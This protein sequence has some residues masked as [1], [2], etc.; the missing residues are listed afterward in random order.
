MFE[1]ITPVS[2][3]ILTI[4]WLV[5]LGLYLG[6]LRQSKAVGGTVAVLL[7]ILAI[8]AFR[9]L[10]ES[11]YFGLY[12]NSLYGFL[13]KGIHEVLLQP[14]LISIPKLINIGAGLLVLFLLIRR[15]L[16]RELRERE[17]WILNLEKAKHV[18]EEKEASLSAIFNGIPDAIMFTDTERR[19]ISINS[20]MEKMFGYTIEDLAGKTTAMLYESEEEYQR[21]GRIR[22]NLSAEEITTPYQVNYKRKNGKIFIGEALG[23][24]I[25]EA[26]GE[27][28][29]YIGVI[30]DITERKHTEDQL[31]TALVDA[32]RANQAK[33][34]FLATMSH[35][36][37]TPLNAILGFS[38]MLRS[39]YFG[40]LG[41]DN[42]NIYAN[43]IHTSGEHMLDLVNDMLDVAAI[44]AGKRPMINEDVDIGEIVKDCVRNVEPAAKNSGINLS[45]DVPDGAASLYTDK[46]SII[47]IVYN[48][49]SN[50]LKFTKPGGKV[51]VSVKAADKK[52]SIMVSDTG[53]G[54]SPDKLPTVTDPFSQTHTDPYITQHGTGLGLSIVK[55]LVEAYDG[56]LNIESKVGKGTTITVTFPCQGTEIN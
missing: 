27:V 7:T 36:F 21:Q 33:S 54:I 44:E 8:D 19:I 41:A 12:F 9:T 30:R 22:F 14:E 28:N 32:E 34:E 29:G 24:I 17:D 42:Y 43:D 18:A 38:E 53:V 26:N 31:Q 48:L 52:I 16:P 46:R 39:Q 2:Y 37:R 25:K 11:A 51:L 35:E 10:F 56:E 49:L 15:W 50:A 1:L 23:A 13:P 40:P 6:K 45:L 55:S 5:I 4:L 20:G 3:W 47:Q